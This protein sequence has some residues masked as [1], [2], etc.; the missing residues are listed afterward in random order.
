MSV[1]FIKEK[2]GIMIEYIES[3]GTV[4][5]TSWDSGSMNA[6]GEIK[7]IE[8]LKNLSTYESSDSRF[9]NNKGLK[10]LTDRIVKGVRK[11]NRAQKNKTS[12]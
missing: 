1:I 9:E 12:P 4:H 8:F 5:I 11:N 6:G 7:L 2:S 3:R 10:R